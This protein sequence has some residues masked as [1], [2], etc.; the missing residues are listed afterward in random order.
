M[1]SEKNITQQEM[2]DFLGESQ[3]YINLLIKNKI[4]QPRIDKLKKFAKKTDTG[5]SFWL[6]ST[7]PEKEQVIKI[8]IHI[9]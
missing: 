8:A 1:K 2:A 5:L 3:Q 6:T 9:K 4:P 7:G